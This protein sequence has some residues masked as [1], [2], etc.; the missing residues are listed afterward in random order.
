MDA[1]RTVDDVAENF[2]NRR[3]GLIKALTSGTR[4]LRTRRSSAVSTVS[5]AALCDAHPRRYVNLRF[6][7]KFRAV[8]GRVSRE[9]TCSAMRDR[10]LRA[11]HI[12]CTS[13]P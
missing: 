7:G 5:I 13:L 6:P 3:E 1:P 9:N 12:V 2:Q 10:R 4:S 8:S 11:S